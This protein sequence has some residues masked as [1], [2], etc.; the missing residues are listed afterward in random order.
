MAACSIEGCSG[1]VRARGWCWKHYCRWRDHG[2]PNAA[3]LRA[4]VGPDVCVIDGCGKPHWARGWCGMH[5]ARWRRTGDPLADLPPFQELKRADIVYGTQHQ[6]L[7]RARGSAGE[8][9]CVD[10]GGPARDWSYDHTDPD[11]RVDSF[12]FSLDFDRYEPRCRS[13]HKV[14]DALFA[15]TSSEGRGPSD[16][17]AGGHH[18][19]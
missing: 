18:D 12:V 16:V 4:R 3:P 19:R 7:R 15:D 13:C 14:F 9:L 2:D 8:L 10:C 1:K 11:E 6:R 17:S 5:L